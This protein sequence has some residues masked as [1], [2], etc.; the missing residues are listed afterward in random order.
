[1]MTSLLLALVSSAHAGFTAGLLAG[2]PIDRFSNSERVVLGTV[3]EARCAE[4]TPM[5]SEVVIDV[6]ETM[7][8]LESPTVSVTMR[9]GCEGL[10]PGNGLKLSIRRPRLLVGEEVILFLR[11]SDHPQTL[12][13]L[14]P[15]YKGYGILKRAP[16]DC[17]EEFGKEVA[18]FNP[19]YFCAQVHIPHDACVPWD[20]MIEIVN[21]E[22]K[23]KPR[24]FGESSFFAEER[25]RYATPTPAL[26]DVN[27]P[28]INLDGLH[29]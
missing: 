17:A 19:T 27:E 8:G 11:R 18:S 13:E 5:R 24:P 29:P 3:T 25:A 6:R 20:T 26:W 7:W 14:E 9:N 16:S 28:G 23:K 12:G 1:M 4:D 15:L 21:A 22:S 10:I 2:P